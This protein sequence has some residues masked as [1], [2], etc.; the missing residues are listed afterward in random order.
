MAHDL[1][2][3]LW[4][5]A[6][7]GMPVFQSINLCFQHYARKGIIASPMLTLYTLDA[8]EC[9]RLITHL[10]ASICISVVVEVIIL[11]FSNVEEPFSHGS[12]ILPTQAT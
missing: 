9:F 10:A 2:V 11:R 7:V 5:Y 8:P 4:Y 6:R 3:L 1:F 12:M